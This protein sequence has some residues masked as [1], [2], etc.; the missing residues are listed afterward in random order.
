MVNFVATKD[1][2][3]VYG[4][5]IHDDTEAV[6]LILNGKA[7]GIFPDGTKITDISQSAGRFL[8]RRPVILTK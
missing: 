3:T 7:I 5:G 8:I 2:V 4:D 1:T 6:G